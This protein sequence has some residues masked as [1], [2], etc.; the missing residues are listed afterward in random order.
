M[1][2]VGALTTLDQEFGSGS[3][4]AEMPNPRIVVDG[5]PARHSREERIHYYQFLRF[6][7]E[8][9]CIGIRDHQADIVSNYSRLFDAERMREPMN[10]DCG[11]LHVETI[12]GN[13]RVA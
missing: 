9:R 6:R 12:L 5:L 2:E 11:R 10:T 4:E 13:R 3:V 1:F 7:G 8:L